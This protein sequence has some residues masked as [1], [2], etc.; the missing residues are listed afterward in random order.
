VI[1]Y[2][3]P[4]MRNVTLAIYNALGE[5]VRTLVSGIQ[6]AG[7]YSVLWDA[8]NDSGNKI[9]SGIYIYTLRAGDYNS[10]KKMILLK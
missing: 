7:Y 10:V 6:S 5:K 9:G 1:K 8:K 4:E 2:D 3:L